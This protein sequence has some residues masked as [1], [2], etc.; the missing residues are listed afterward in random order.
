MSSQPEAD[1]TERLNRVDMAENAKHL[2][3]TRMTV[4]RDWEVA[5]TFL[6]KRLCA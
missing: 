4:H 6:S 3:V 5:R 1:I 2:G